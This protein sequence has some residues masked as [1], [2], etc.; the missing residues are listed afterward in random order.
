MSNRNSLKSTNVQQLHMKYIRKTPD[1]KKKIKKI[2][3]ARNIKVVKRQLSNGKVHLCK[4]PSILPNI[5]PH[6]G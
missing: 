5:F 4:K 1:Q 2:M 6:I 3:K